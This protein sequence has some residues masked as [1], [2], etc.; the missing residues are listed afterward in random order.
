MRTLP[1]TKT[2]AY[3]AVLLGIAVG[4]SRQIMAAAAAAAAAPDPAARLKGTPLVR[5]AK[6]PNAVVSSLPA[7][8]A[9]AAETPMH[10]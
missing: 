1:A 2:A 5:E 4:P 10:Y 6:L 9:A 7:H 3:A 8:P